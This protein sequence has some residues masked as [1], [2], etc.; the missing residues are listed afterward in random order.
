MYESETEHEYSPSGSPSVGQAPKPKTSEPAHATIIGGSSAGA[1]F[2][3]GAA[4]L[5]IVGLIG[6][7]PAF[8]GPI[9][10]IAAGA[11]L[12]AEGSARALWYSQSGRYGPETIGSTTMGGV[13]VIVLSI[14]ALIGLSMN[15]LLPTAVLVLGTSLFLASWAFPGGTK[16]LT[17]LT[18][19]VL[20]VLALVGFAPMTL[21]L[22]AFLCV[23]CGLLFSDSAWA[24]RFA[25]AQS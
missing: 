18:G 9:A 15:V 6:V 3:L 2:G 23:G 19:M 7:A 14:L 22:A 1:F 16:F 24:G 5:G 4:V 13:A 8:L 21:C 25:Q 17:G 11:A 20:G 10:G 12:L